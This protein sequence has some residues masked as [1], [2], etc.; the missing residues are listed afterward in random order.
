M[1]APAAPARQKAAQTRN[2]SCT[3]YQGSALPRS[4]RPLGTGAPPCLDP[5]GSLVQR[6]SAL[7]ATPCAGGRPCQQRCMQATCAGAAPAAS[8]AN[9]NGCT[10]H[11]LVA[12]RRQ[13]LPA[14]MAALDGGRSCQQ[15]CMQAACAEASPAAAPASLDG[16]RR[17]APKPCLWPLLP[18]NFAA[19]GMRCF[20]ARGCPCP[21]PCMRAA[22]AE[23]SPAAT[24]ANHTGCKGHA[25]VPRRRLH[26]PTTVP[27]CG[28]PRGRADG[29]SCQQPWMPKA[30]AEASPA[31]ALAS[32][33]GCNRPALMRR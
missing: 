29:S 22:C 9:P 16:S 6:G 4:A 30:R 24:P 10:G 12:C 31:A 14:T 5:Q 2:N 20:R 27:A 25:L 11:A 21:Q 7:Q 17:N 15:P 13:L 32:I 33:T 26:L 28:M 23:A 18:A 3:R 1:F 8:P 19:S